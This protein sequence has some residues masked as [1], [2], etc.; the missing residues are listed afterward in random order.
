MTTP[1][2]DV[3]IVGAGSAGLSAA[4]MLARSRR[5]VIVLDGGAPRNAVAAHMHGVLGRD[6]WSP[7]ELVATGRREVEDYGAAIEQRAAVA[8][9][10]TAVG[11][12]VTL[13]DGTTR[14]ARRLLV[15]GGL[16]D[17]LPD[18]PGLAGQW[19]RGVAHCPY[20]D[21]WEV[22]DK[23]LGVL[24]TAATSAHFAQLV[25]QLSER[26][27]YFVEGTELPP[28]S[29]EALLARGISVEERRIAF[30]TSS[31][32]RLTGVR[33][34]DG[35]E[36]PLDAVFVRSATHPADGLLR[37][38]GAATAVAPDGTSWVSVDATGRT[39]V[40]GLWAAGNVVDPSATVP[41]ASAAGTRAGMAVNADLVEDEVR[42]SLERKPA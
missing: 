31:R 21:G 9:E 26:L 16:R 4:L 30:V 13:D 33:L 25:R 20:C 5:R 8:A 32:D 2:A 38:L 7:L 14:T 6:G 15:A 22:R 28:E 23:R 42:L 18:V 27:T 3:L 12:V 36:L 39:S 10:R 17:E 35:A 29:R 37:Q 1:D 19:G 34:Q 41:L 11:F 24:A 40:A